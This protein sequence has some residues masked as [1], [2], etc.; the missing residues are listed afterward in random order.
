MNFFTEFWT[1]YFDFKGRTS[2]KN[3]WL[4]RLM[5]FLIGIILSYIIKIPALSVIWSLAVFIPSFAMDIRR[6]HDTNRSGKWFLAVYIP[7]IVGLILVFSMLGNMILE[8]AFSTELSNE[9]FTSLI[10]S[11]LSSMGLAMLC[12]LVGFIFWIVII[13]FQIFP[14]V[15]EN[16]KYGELFNSSLKM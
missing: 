8:S 1:R 4:T 10:I 16:N 15:N 3:F 12:E 14:S 6:L 7:M 5:L 9:Q 2:R 11:N 13:I